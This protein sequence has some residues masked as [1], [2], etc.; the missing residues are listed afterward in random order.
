[1]KTTLKQ[2]GLA[3]FEVVAGKSPSEAKAV[4][5]KFVELLVR[6]NMLAK[7]DKIIAEFVEIWHERNGI[8]LAEVRSANGLDKVNIKL[9]KKY[10]AGLT[11][12]KEVLLNEKIDKNI[13]GGVVIR[14]GDKVI[15]GSLR[16]QL[17]ELRKKMVK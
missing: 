13:L 3:L 10:I 9:L 2:Y 17:E 1:M 14:Y 4:I 6:E 16:T 5:K 11:G 15:D 8:T 7:V 12:A